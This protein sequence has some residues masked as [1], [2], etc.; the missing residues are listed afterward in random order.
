[1]T[2]SERRILLVGA[3]GY[4]GGRLLRVLEAGDHSIRCVARRPAAV[5]TSRYTTEVVTGDCLD[6]SS[7]DKACSGIHT[8]Y[9]LVHSMGA[10]ARF[11]ELD[12]TA[13]LNFG[14][15]AARAGVRRIIYLGGLADDSGAASVHLK[16]RA[17]TGEVLRASGV[18]VAEFRS[19][20][21]IGAGSLSFQMIQALVER[22]PVMVCPRWLETPTQPIAIDDVVAYLAAA[23]DLPETSGRVFEIGGPEV[24]SYGAIMR[25]Y[26]RQRGLRRLLL[27]I[28]LL[29]PHLSGLWLA[30]V[31][32]AQA[33]VG[34]ALVEGLRS[35]TIVRS[36]DALHAFD[37]ERTPLN[38]AIAKAI[39]EG[40][41]ARMKHDTRTIDV[42]ATPEHAFAPIRRIGG[43]SGWYFCTSLWK[44]RGL[45]DRALGGVGMTRGRR[46]PE[47]CA[48]GDVV[49][50]WTIESYL[51][52]RRLRLSADLK[53]P[54]RGW[55]EFEVTPAGGGRSRVRQQATFD[56]RGVLGRVY[57]Y[58]LLPI[59]AILF[60]GLIRGI[61]RRAEHDA[62]RD[63]D[64]FVHRSVVSAPA[65]K[66]F[67]WHERPESL[68]ALLPPRG[69]RLESRSGGVQDGG[70]ATLSMGLG[71]FRIRWEALHYGY[72][73]GKQF[74]DK[75][76]RGPFRTWRHTHRVEAISPSQCVYEDRVEYALPGGLLVRHL[77]NGLVRRQL[78]RMFAQ[79]HDVVRAQFRRATVTFQGQ[80]DMWA[81]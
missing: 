10:G 50:W 77:T 5:A 34:R 63:V 13:A 2:H 60:G 31:T 19:S 20:I 72:V 22:L 54:G 73:A 71:P 39:E 29:T 61:A 37:I 74:C 66:V 6:E 32:P 65:A 79:R 9:Y 80:A 59:H 62:L 68:Y 75:Q 23:L 46:D 11:A 81:R 53:L 35:T 26:A 55:L 38:V 8:A 12:K 51:P 64:V 42:E 76:L 30:L 36:D 52:D 3:T 24:L 48:V 78:T 16:S 1:M 43:D 44:L 18:P 41:P 58:I 25:E 56:P 27:P 69:V 33:R 14:R 40:A 67:H 70:R 7:L 57:W 28:P 45:I 15:A 17:E 21:I 47:Q 4:V 49:D